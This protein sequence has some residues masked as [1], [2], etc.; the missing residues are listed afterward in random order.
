MLAWSRIWPAGVGAVLA[1][2]A[3]Q[4]VGR[5]TV[6]L[7]HADGN[8]VSRVYRRLVIMR[9][10]PMGYTD[11]MLYKPTRTHTLVL[12]TTLWKWKPAGAVLVLSYTMRIAMS[13]CAHAIYGH[14]DRIELFNMVNHLVIDSAELGRLSRSNGFAPVSLSSHWV[15]ITAVGSRRNINKVEMEPWHYADT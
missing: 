3:C 10:S 4:D 11:N 2:L 9:A 14:S 15:E 6:T 13:D 7:R 8:V 1:W 5:R 12:T